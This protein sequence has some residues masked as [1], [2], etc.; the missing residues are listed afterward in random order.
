MSRQLATVATLAA[1]AA[2]AGCGGGDG[3]GGDRLSK[4]D[5]I[6]QADALCLEADQRIEALGDPTTAEEAVAFTRDA[7]A[8]AEEQ[9]ARL[10][11][12]RP[13][14]E[15]EA[16]LE[17]AY[18]LLEQQIEVGRQLGDAI[19]ANDEARAQELIRQ[20]DDLNERANEIAD[21]YGMAECGT[22][23]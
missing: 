7:T 4:E 23:P 1:A 16:T 17:E 18:D 15:D 9:L 20:G 3:E 13:P 12:L 14:E 6:R 10:R 22:S 11:A 5:Y 21:D 19:D 8:I 2:L